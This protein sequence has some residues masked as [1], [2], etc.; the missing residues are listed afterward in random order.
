MRVPVTPIR[1]RCSA[2]GCNADAVGWLVAP[3]GELCPGA[4]ICEQHRVQIVEEFSFKLGESWTCAPLNGGQR[5]KACGLL[6]D[7]QEFADACCAAG[8]PQ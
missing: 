3:D 1:P 2:R 6:F 4:T 7:G 8:G 5:C